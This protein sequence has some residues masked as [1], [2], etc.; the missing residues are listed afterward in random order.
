MR[1]LKSQNGMVHV[2]TAGGTYSAG[3]IDCAQGTQSWIRS[4]SA[5]PLPFVKVIVFEPALSVTLS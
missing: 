1:R 4:N 2:D 3:S 5:K